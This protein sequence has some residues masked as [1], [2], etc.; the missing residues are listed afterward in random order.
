L[1]WPG[2][3]AGNVFIVCRIGEATRVSRTGTAGIPGSEN[4]YRRRGVIRKTFFILN[5]WIATRYP[6]GPRAHFDMMFCDEQYGPG[7]QEMFAAGKSA[8]N[9]AGLPCAR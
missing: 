3:A 7:R 5:K 2:K 6:C 4:Q 9:M 1:K 8:E